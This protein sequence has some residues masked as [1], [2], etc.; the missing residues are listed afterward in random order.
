MQ[1]V[2]ISQDKQNNK[3]VALVENGKLVEKYE[4]K[5]DQKRLEG[6]IYIGKVENVLIGMQ[7]AFINIGAEK[8]TFIHIK[9]IIPKVSN[10]TGNKNEKLGNY[11]IKNYIKQ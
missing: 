8:N 11:D 3:I 10:E 2:I 4:E 6:N 1:E 7:A 5:A 9:D